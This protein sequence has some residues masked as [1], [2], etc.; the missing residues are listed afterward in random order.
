[1]PILRSIQNSA[2][3]MLPFI[4]YSFKWL[5]RSSCTVFY[6]SSCTV[7]PFIVYSRYPIFSEEAYLITNYEY[8]YMKEIPYEY[9]ATF[10]LG[11]IHSYFIQRQKKNP[12]GECLQRFRRMFVGK[13]MIFKTLHLGERM[14]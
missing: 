13:P 6:R 5:Y 9:P 8:Y 14:F 10:G 1:M 11:N 4:V 12:V 3:P 7:L 2:E